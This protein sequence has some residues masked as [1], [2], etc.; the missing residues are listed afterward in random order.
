MLSFNSFLSCEANTAGGTLKRAVWFFVGIF[1]PKS[2][3]D[4]LR[5]SEVVKDVHVETLPP[6]YSIEGLNEAAQKRLPWLDDYERSCVLTWKE[7]CEREG[8]DARDTGIDL[9][10]EEETGLI[11]AIQCKFYAEATRVYKKDIDSFFTESGKKPF[12]HRLIVLSTGD[13][14]EHV[15]N[16]TINQ[17][18]PCSTLHLDDL[19][20]SPIDWAQYRHATK[21]IFRPK[22]QLQPHQ[23][24]AVAVVTAR[25]LVFRVLPAWLQSKVAM[26]T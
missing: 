1:V 19:E 15:H 24:K 22:K 16:A 8:K 26:S 14:S 9:V 18:V 7:W 23:K 13:V 2:I 11:W 25:E 21:A 12:G 17:Q 10:A 6:K 20:A 4:R 5:M 3:N